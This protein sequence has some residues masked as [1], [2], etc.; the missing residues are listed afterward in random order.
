[1]HT[2]NAVDYF[3]RSLKIERS[4]LIEMCFDGIT[5]QVDE[6]TVAVSVVM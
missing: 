6:R 5:I 3:T 4:F 1:M 2:R